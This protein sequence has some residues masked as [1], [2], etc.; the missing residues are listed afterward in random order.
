[1]RSTA[2]LIFICG[3]MA[4]HVL[5]LP[6][7]DPVPGA[8]VAVRPPS[9]GTVEPTA[10]R[11]LLESTVERPGKTTTGLPVTCHPENDNHAGDRVWAALDNRRTF[12]TLFMIAIVA[13]IAMSAGFGLGRLLHRNQNQPADTSAAAA[14]IAHAIAYLEGHY[15]DPDI[16]I[17]KVAHEVG[18][19]Q[20][21]LGS[22]FRRETD[23]SFDNYLNRLRANK[24]AEML[25]EQP[26]MK[27]P[28][29]ASATGFPTVDLFRSTFEYVHGTP[30]E[31]FAQSTA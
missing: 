19:H 3:L 29:V 30:P 21:F 22:L 4:S 12:P 24:A 27:I 18:L 1:M 20:V 2:T 10:A 26:D 31:Q 5:S 11:S 13:L 14:R 9:R 6:P 8:M 25:R 17:G 7:T 28:D 23:T 16:T 15:A